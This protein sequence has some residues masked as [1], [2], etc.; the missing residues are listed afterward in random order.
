MPDTDKGSDSNTMF[1]TCTSSLRER[2]LSW[3]TCCTYSSNNTSSVADKNKS[4]L[5]LIRDTQGESHQK[6]LI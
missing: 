6:N 1:E 5:K 4:L 3:E 2:S